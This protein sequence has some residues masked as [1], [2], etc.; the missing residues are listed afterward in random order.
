MDARWSIPVVK[1]SLYVNSHRF[2]LPNRI[3]SQQ[4][5][6]LSKKNNENDAAITSGLWLHAA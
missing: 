4:A 5:L 3:F 2:G 1:T 6:L